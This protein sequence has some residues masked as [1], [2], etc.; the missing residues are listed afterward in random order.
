MNLE[1]SNLNNA[2][3]FYNRLTGQKPVTISGNIVTYQSWRIS[4]KLIEVNHSIIPK[5]YLLVIPKYEDFKDLVKRMFSLSRHHGP[6]NCELLEDHFS[7]IDSD[8]HQWWISMDDNFSI[9]GSN[10]CYLL[11]MNF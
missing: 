5:K 3:R 9:I 11:P 7:I 8:G 10:P 2:I 4:F 6:P 1:V